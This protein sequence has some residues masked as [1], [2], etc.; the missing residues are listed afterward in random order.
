MRVL[1]THAIA[2]SLQPAV[3]VAAALRQLR[4]VQ[5]DPIRAPARAVDLILRQRVANYRAGDLD[6]QYPQLPL[7]EDY[8]HIYAV[9]TAETRA[10]LHP[11]GRPYLLHIESEHPRLPA[12]VLAHVARNGDAHPR[13][14]AAALGRVQ[15]RSGWGGVS[16]ATT[17]ALEAL[18]YR[19][20][21]HVTRREQG[22]KVYSLATPWADPLPP[23][24]RAR[25]LMLLLLESYAPLP[26]N[27]YW[28]LVR[29]ITESSLS[30]T[31]RDR[32]WKAM[33]TDPQIERIDIDGVT[34]VTPAD[35]VRRNDVPD[36]V[37]L[38]APF[39]PV[40]WDRR[41]FAAFW[42]WEYR[43]E[44]YTPA[45]KRQ[46]GYYALPLLWRDDVIGWANAI[47]AAG[48]LQVAAQYVASPPRSASYRHALAAECERLRVCVGADAVQVKAA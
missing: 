23:A 7:A 10:L 43:L 47:V 36:R 48:T 35:E 20:K 4:F 39:D 13:D 1:R 28:Q 9:M 19:G 17:R 46:F 29:M 3:D 26:E 44:A 22:I 18:H 34:W 31:L 2:R 32:T 14:L 12:R 24:A 40:V 37:R 16:T 27:S 41:R 11:R 21:L 25:A 6:R 8:L 33:R 42:G 45:A 5:L 15:V 38:L 30:A